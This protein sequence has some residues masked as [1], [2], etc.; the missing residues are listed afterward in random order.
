MLLY[1]IKTEELTPLI[2]STP[3]HKKETETIHP[4]N[5]LSGDKLT[6]KQATT[7]G[8]TLKQELGIHSMSFGSSV[9]RDKI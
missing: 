8:E 9:G 3:L 1:F 4:V 7:I 6:L 5:I 2:I